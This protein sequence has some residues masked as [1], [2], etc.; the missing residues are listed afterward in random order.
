MTSGSDK[1]E[2]HRPDLAHFQ[3]DEYYC[4]MEFY[5]SLLI[6]VRTE[7]DKSVIQ[8]IGALNYRT[9]RALRDFFAQKLEELA[10]VQHVSH[11][12]LDLSQLES[13]DSTALGALLL[14]HRN[15]SKINKDFKFKI[16]SINRQIKSILDDT[17]FYR[18]FE[19]VS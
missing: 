8:L 3:T 10:E 9:Q 7:K 17:N 13:L 12:Y 11:V 1:G 14:I 4:S 6:Q 2:S 18:F 15:Y 19:F 16:L 5:K